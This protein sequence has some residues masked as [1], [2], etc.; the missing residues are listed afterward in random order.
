VAENSPNLKI[1]ETKKLIL[2]IETALKKGSIALLDDEVEIGTDF[3]GETVSTSQSLLTGIENL[4]QKNDVQK[5]DIGL[6]AVSNGPGSLTGIRIGIATALG[7]ATAWG[8][9]CVGVSLFEAI[10]IGLEKPI[11]AFVSGVR[12]ESYF[13]YFEV[14]STRQI[15]AVRNENLQLII[16]EF[17]SPTVVVEESLTKILSG[18]KNI[19][20]PHNLAYLVGKKSTLIKLNESATK[21]LPLYLEQNS[22]KTIIDKM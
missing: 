11:L 9:K 2:A 8:I 5:K 21:P 16:D 18:R 15:G 6:I 4:L 19:F 17:N 20:V 1:E 12:G 10:S 3:L 14:N 22:F 7:L 13:Q